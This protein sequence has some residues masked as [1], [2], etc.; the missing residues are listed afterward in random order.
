M[1]SKIQK[2]AEKNGL[3]PLTYCNK[4]SKDIYRFNK[5]IKFIK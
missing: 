5:K 1:V 4:I 3:D 2:A